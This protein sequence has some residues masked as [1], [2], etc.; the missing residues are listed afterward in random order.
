MTSDQII[1]AIEAIEHGKNDGKK[2]DTGEVGADGLVHFSTL[3]QWKL[4]RE[5]RGL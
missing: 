4:F 2:E 3:E 5:L 1:I